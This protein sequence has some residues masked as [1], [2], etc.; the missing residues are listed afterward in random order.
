MTN[1]KTDPPPPMEN[2][3]AKLIEQLYEPDLDELSQLAY[4]GWAA[5]H[6][7]LTMLA[8]APWSGLDAHEKSKWNGAIR[9]LG[10]A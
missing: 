5:E 2:P 8:C 1:K 7:R 3:E 6:Y 4:A 9:A 10:I